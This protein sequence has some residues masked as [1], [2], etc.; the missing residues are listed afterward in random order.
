MTTSFA[1][2]LI[3]SRAQL[4]GAKGK[5]IAQKTG[6]DIPSP[7]IGVCSMHGTT[8]LCEGCWRSLEE[9]AGWSRANDTD[10]HAV[11]AR[12]AQRIAPYI[13]HSTA[14]SA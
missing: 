14:P 11:W 5:N 7:C 2:N 6:P 10:K 3:A 12:I 4:V 1:I 9:I 13:D 8:G